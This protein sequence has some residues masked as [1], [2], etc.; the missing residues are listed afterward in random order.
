MKGAA[1]PLV[2]LKC[3]EKW[4]PTGPHG[5]AYEL[6]EFM[7]IL[8]VRNGDKLL[9]DPDTDP[10]DVQVDFQRF[11]KLSIN[12][13]DMWILI[14]FT[15]DVTDYT[16]QVLDDIRLELERRISDWFRNYEGLPQ[17]DP[18]APIYPTIAV[19]IFWGPGKGFLMNGHG[20]VIKIW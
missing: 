19:D 11:D 7:P 13:V 18:E 15:E 8:L 9:L 6:G 4:Y 5:V 2:T 3:Q 16:L 20:K 1:M 14:V 12:T 17:E 10:Q